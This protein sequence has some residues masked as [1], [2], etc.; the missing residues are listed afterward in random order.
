MV[1]VILGFEP[2]SK[3][4]QSPK[5]VIEV[6]DPRLVLIDVAVPDFLTTPSP[7]GT[8]DAQLQAPLITK[9]LHSQEQPI[10]SDDEAKEGMPKPT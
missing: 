4:F 9:L 10:P 3:R 7:F 6:K 8:Q 1:H 2:I 5:H